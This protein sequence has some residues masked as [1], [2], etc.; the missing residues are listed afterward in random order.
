MEY[1]T[2]GKRI[3]LTAHLRRVRRQERVYT[4]LALWTQYLSIGSLALYGLLRIA[5]CPGIPLG[6]YHGPLVLLWPAAYL[7]LLTSWISDLT[8][9]REERRSGAA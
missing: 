3:D 8:L 1:T 6:R 7:L 4:F 9:W 5:A 2:V